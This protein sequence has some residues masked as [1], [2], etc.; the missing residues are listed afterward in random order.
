MTFIRLVVLLLSPGF[1]LSLAQCLLALLLDL[2]GDLI[3][4]V[5]PERRVGRAL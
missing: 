3:H 5:A 4:F 2:L 1:L